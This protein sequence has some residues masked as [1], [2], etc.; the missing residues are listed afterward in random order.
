[1][2]K[3]TILHPEP[4]DVTRLPLTALEAF[5][6]SQVDGKLKLFEVAERAAFSPD[7]LEVAGI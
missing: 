5:F 2:D 3:N 1:M 7:D 4:C 6:L